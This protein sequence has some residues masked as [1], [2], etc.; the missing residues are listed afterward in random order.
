MDRKPQKRPKGNRQT[1]LIAALLLAASAA[2]LLLFYSSISYLPLLLLALCCLPPFA[3][4]L[5]LLLP[6]GRV[7]EKPAD[8]APE[9]SADKK[10]LRRQKRAARRAG[11]RIR[12]H[13]AYARRRDTIVAVLWMLV[14]IGTNI[15][16]WLKCRLDLPT[17]RFGYTVPVLLLAL[18]VIL[19]ILDKWCKH[20]APVAVE[21]EELSPADTYIVALLHSLRS[22]AAVAKIGTVIV[23]VAAVI[24]LLGTYNPAKIAVILLAVL[25]AYETLFLMLSLVVRL[26]RRELSTVPDFSVPVPG[27]GGADLGFL[28]YLEKHTG[29]TMRSLWS[30]RL[31]KTVIPYAFIAALV[32][33]WGTSGVV[34]I[35]SSEQGAHYRLGKLSDKPLTAGIHFTLPWPFDRVEVYDT[36]KVQQMTIG[37]LTDDSMDNLWTAEHG[38]EEHRLLL[39]GGEELVSVNLRVEYKIGDLN[40]YLKNSAA[41]ESILQAMAYEALTMRTISTDLDTLLATDRVAFADDMCAELRERAAERELGLE[42]VGVVLESIHPPV[43]IADIYQKLLSAGIDAERII[44]MAEATAAEA[45]VSA[46]TGKT[47]LIGVATAE[48]NM[49]IA[50]AH[51]SVAEFLAAVE[52][53]KAYPDFYRYEKYLGAIT[54]AYGNATIVLVGDGVNTANLYIGKLN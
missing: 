6:F 39:G 48:K 27:V 42:V 22:A 54:D 2:V 46:N 31:V 24:R 10:T 3:I 18:F 25:F 19:T 12:A 29:I 38:T 11:A 20:S 4:S 7:L 34:Q 1:A 52:A 43:E 37:Y 30:I 5:V 32:I 51:G 17:V 9:A 23:A 28:S 33:L 40:A 14:L 41:P 13:N 15:M 16:F 44:L 21:G 50:A 49:A 45:L 8:A 35:E 47:T 26:I 36:G 53:D